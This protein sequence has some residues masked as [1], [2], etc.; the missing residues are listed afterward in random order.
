M[1]VRKNFLKIRHFKKYQFFGMSNCAVSQANFLAMD[2]EPV[3]S[4]RKFC[5]TKLDSIEKTWTFFQC[6][7]IK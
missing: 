3:K 6:R 7:A 5:E 4:L 2:G 1:I